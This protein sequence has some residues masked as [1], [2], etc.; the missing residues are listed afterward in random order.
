MCILLSA[1]LSSGVD[2]GREHDC[3]CALNQK[4]GATVITNIIFSLRKG[5]LSITFIPSAR[6]LSFARS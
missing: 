3:L 2:D 1:A 4:V 6:S 5:I